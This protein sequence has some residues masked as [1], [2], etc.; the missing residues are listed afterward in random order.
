MIGDAY[1]IRLDGKLLFEVREIVLAVGVLDMG[2]QFVSFVH[3]VIASSQ[4]VAGCAHG[5]GIDIGSRQRAT[6]K[7]NGNFPGVYFVVFT[8][9]AMD[10]FHV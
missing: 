4:E 9:A 1:P 8:L 6:P 2:Q 7:Q 3:E 10:G 5:L